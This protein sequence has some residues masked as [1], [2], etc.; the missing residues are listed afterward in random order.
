MGPKFRNADGVGRKTSDIATHH[1]DY[2]GSTP[3]N[4][5]AT[6]LEVLQDF[7]ERPE[8]MHRVAKLIREGLKTGSL[9]DATEI[10][11]D[12]DDLDDDG[13]PEGRHLARKHFARG[14]DKTLREKKLKQHLLAHGVLACATC[15]GHR[16]FPSSTA[17]NT[18]SE[19]L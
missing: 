2:K 17:S 6:D 15:G 12:V 5:G 9:L 14:R 3:T 8:E 18:S 16:Y 10:V 1:P 4:A 13:V 11:N 7:L 19:C